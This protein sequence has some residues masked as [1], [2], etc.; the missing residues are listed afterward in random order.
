LDVVPRKEDEMRVSTRSVVVVALAAAGALALGTVALGAGNSTA[1][2]QFSPNQVPKDVYTKGSL[3][4]H[5]H[6]D[7][8]GGTKTLRAQLNFDNDLKITTAGIPQCNKASV[9][10]TLTLQQAMAACGNAKVGAGTA[11][12]NLISPGDVHGCVLAFNGKPSSGNPTLLL[13]TR[14]QVPGSINCSNPASNTNGNGSVLLE[15]VIRPA[16]GDFGMQLDVNN[17]PQA[18]PLSDFKTTVSRGNYISARCHHVHLHQPEQ[19][20]DGERQPDLSGGP[21]PAPAQHADHQGEDQPEAQEGEVQLQGDGQRDGLRVPARTE[22]PQAQGL[23]Q[24][25]LA[26]GLQAPEEGQV[27]LRG[28]GRRPR[29]KG[30]LAR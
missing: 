16:S 24:L 27:H 30:P 20:P 1:T 9:S 28:A 13:F 29:W 8:T 23:L 6:T 4:V 25:R 14:L 26:E 18:S 3:F 2:F 17:I 21:G 15:G 22:A 12:A 7:Y 5:T 19:H 10:G 11:Q